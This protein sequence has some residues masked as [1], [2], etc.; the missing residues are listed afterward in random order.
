VHT[1]V[2][3]GDEEGVYKPLRDIYHC[4][5]LQSERINKEVVKWVLTE[6]SKNRKEVAALVVGLG[7]NGLYSTILLLMAGFDVVAVSDR[8]E[9]PAGYTRERLPSVDMTLVERYRLLWGQH[10]DEQFGLPEWLHPKSGMKHHGVLMDMDKN[11]RR[12]RLDLNRIEL[13]FHQLLKRI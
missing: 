2:E 10:F 5:A 13:A 12:G 6:Y 4:S 8:D 11:F 9:G 1:F 7:P 3:A